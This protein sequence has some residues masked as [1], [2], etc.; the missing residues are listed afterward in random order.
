MS[1][2]VSP[3]ANLPRVT[4]TVSSFR[5]EAILFARVECAEVAMI[6]ILEFELKLF[7]IF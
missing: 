4:G 5:W 7:A 3:F 6:L 2:F 1:T